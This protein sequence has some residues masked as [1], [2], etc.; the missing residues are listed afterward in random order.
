VALAGY[1]DYPVGERKQRQRHCH[2]CSMNDNE[3]GI[4]I[5][6]LTSLSMI[7]VNARQVVEVIF[8][9]N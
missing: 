7:F 4:Y 6:H 1:I 3:D 8:T 9:V 2:P 5:S